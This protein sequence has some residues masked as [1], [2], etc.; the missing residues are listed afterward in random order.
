MGYL[1]L[2]LLVNGDSL[3]PMSF[4]PL[5]FTVPFDEADGEGIVFFGNYFRLAHRALEQFLPSIGIPWAEW[6]KNPDW[7][8]PLRHVEADYLRPLRPGDQ[9]EAKI[10]VS[11]LGESSVHFGY[12]FLDLA[13]KPLARLTTSHVFVTRQGMKKTPVPSNVRARLEHHLKK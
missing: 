6:F 5:I 2:T 11:E 3:P 13:G 7:G 4:T 9:F 1:E 8:V 12:E 10:V